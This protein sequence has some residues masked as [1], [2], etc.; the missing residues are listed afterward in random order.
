MSDESDQTSVQIFCI[1]YVFSSR[2]SFTPERKTHL[3]SDW[4][5]WFVYRSL[6]HVD[7]PWTRTV[8]TGAPLVITYAAI[9]FVLF[10][11]ELKMDD[12]PLDSIS[13][14]S[15]CWDCSML[16]S[17]E[18]RF[19]GVECLLLRQG[20]YR[21]LFTCPLARPAGLCVTQQWW[22]WSTTARERSLFSSA[23]G[24]ATNRRLCDVWVSVHMCVC[25]YVHGNAKVNACGVFHTKLLHLLCDEGEGDVTQRESQSDISC[26]DLCQGF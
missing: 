8:Y 6:R 5:L 13:L 1:F 25:V 11:P 3:M 12:T 2:M 9:E 22:Q 18:N 10:G 23:N 20:I 16:S 4:T 19:K 26:L 24:S 21:P 15:L 7:P 17:I 14:L